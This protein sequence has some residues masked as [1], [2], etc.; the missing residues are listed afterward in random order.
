MA[1]VV[2]GTI[3]TFSGQKL[4]YSVMGAWIEATRH[5]VEIDKNV[6]MLN[7]TIVHCVDLSRLHIVRAR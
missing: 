1:H 3:G 5:S 2:V 4:P 7:D 6:T